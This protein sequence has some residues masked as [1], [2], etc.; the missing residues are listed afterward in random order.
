[1]QADIRKGTMDLW[2]QNFYSQNNFFAHWETHKS[3]T[4]LISY[5]QITCGYSKNWGP[6]RHLFQNAIGDNFAKN[7]LKLD[8]NKYIQILEI[9]TFWP[10]FVKINPETVREKEKSTIWCKLLKV[11]ITINSKKK[12]TSNW[13]KNQNFIYPWNLPNTCKFLN[14]GPF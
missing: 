6:F 3:K 9:D 11:L 14:L 2:T 13:M 8:E 12:K 5:K 4:L 7:I 10:L 1:M